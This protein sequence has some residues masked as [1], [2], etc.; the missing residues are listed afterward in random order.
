MTTIGFVGPGEIVPSPADAA[1]L[2]VH[3]RVVG[4][5]RQA[6]AGVFPWSYTD[7]AF[8]NEDLV[9]RQ[10]NPGS[11]PFLVIDEATRHVAYI[12]GAMF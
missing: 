6:Q 11:F 9:R 3:Y 5:S 4:A 1:R 12:D 8:V 10:P 7:A 2:T